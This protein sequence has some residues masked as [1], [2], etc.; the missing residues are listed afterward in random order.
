MTEG[1]VWHTIDVVAYGRKLLGE[2]T[3]DG[4]TVRVRTILG[5]GTA[6]H[7]GKPPASVAR[8]ALIEMAQEGK[9]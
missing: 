9:A 5:A 6:L 1:P 3:V 4:E 8:Y 7:W 2:Y